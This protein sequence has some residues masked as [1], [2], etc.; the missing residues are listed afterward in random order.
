MQVYCRGTFFPCYSSVWLYCV[1]LSSVH[2]RK[3]VILA[4][5]CTST[6]K[7]FICCI[8][9]A[10]GHA[11]KFFPFP[12][13]FFPRSVNARVLAALEQLP[14]KNKAR[15][16]IIKY[17]LGWLPVIHNL[18]GFHYLSMY[19]FGAAAT[20]TAS[21]KARENGHNS[22]IPAQNQLRPTPFS[23]IWS[24][25]S[26]LVLNSKIG[27]C[28]AKW[29]LFS[30]S[31]VTV[32]RWTLILRNI[33]DFPSELK[34]LNFFWSLD[35]LEI[36]D[37]QLFRPLST[38]SPTKISAQKGQKPCLGDRIHPLWGIEVRSF[39]LFNPTWPNSTGK[40]WIHP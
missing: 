17:K 10:E 32:C 36:L 24:A 33:L 25:L 4:Y 20:V 9:V 6:G 23:S 2:Q 28:M 11:Y 16:E 1:V 31:W 21:H 19:T 3:L 18:K 13:D 22:G 34:S 12:E 35:L 27:A 26:I 15:K 8:Y 40:W 37:L 5:T 14:T 29:Q 38:L 39:W 7:E 30:T